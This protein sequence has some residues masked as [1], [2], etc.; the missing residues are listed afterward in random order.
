M[1]SLQVLSAPSNQ[2]TLTGVVSQPAGVPAGPLPVVSKPANVPAKLPVVSKPANVQPS[3]SVQPLP[4]QPNIAVPPKPP[5]LDKIA[6]DIGVARG[7]GA[8]DTAILRSLLQKNPALVP[9]V[10]VAIQERKATPTDVLNAIVAKHAPQQPAQDQSTYGPSAR[11]FDIKGFLEPAKDVLVGYGKGLAKTGAT[12]LKP[13]DKLLGKFGV[14]SGAGLSD[15]ELKPNGIIQNVGYL[16]SQ[17]QQANTI[18][19]AAAPVATA[20]TKSATAVKAPA[21]IQKLLDVGGR[22]AFDAALGYGT[23]KLQGYDNKD[24]KTAALVS[25]ALPWASAA[26]SE[27]GKLAGVNKIGEKIQYALIKPT[28]SDVKNGFKIENVNKYDL[29]GNLEQTAKK[30]QA[31]ISERVAALRSQ[32]G[33]G[34][35]T[36]DLNQ[37]YSDTVD[38]IKALKFE[39]AGSNTAIQAQLDKFA[40]ELESLSKNGVIDI[41]D[42]QDIKRAFGAKGAWEYNVP[43]ED[44]NA[45]ETVYTKAYNTIKQQI[46]NAAA[47]AGNTRV[48]QINKELSDLIP[49]EHAL[50]RRLPVAAR[51]D[52]ISLK[53]LVAAVGGAKFGLPMYVLNKLTKSGTVGAELATLGKRSQSAGP[54]R[55]LIT[56]PG[57]KQL[58][59]SPTISEVAA[60]IPKIPVGLAIQDVSASSLKAEELG[61]KINELNVRWVEKPTPANK[62]AL[63]NAKALY[64]KLTRK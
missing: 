48:K 32:L 1:S 58:E 23:A 51:Q 19:R 28:A 61:K 22:S 54:I 26:F 7:R 31:A 20:I 15:E 59:S 55:T 40:Q 46:E 60:K 43:R 52:P 41:A 64:K 17:A 30:T 8:D 38:A 39:N 10:K 37:T 2:P 16:T 6:S 44:A 63:D 42:A 24:A 25:G 21:A 5:Q 57:A 11:P 13:I 33:K 35:A 45:I 36:V 29:G 27:V 4:Q 34:S 56:G 14:K 12:L 9:D 49:I 3:L 53:D 50:I 62:K 47:S 18:I